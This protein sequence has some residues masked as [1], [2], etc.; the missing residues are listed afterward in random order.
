VSDVLSRLVEQLLVLPVYLAVGLL[1][2]AVCVLPVAIRRQDLDL[3][4]RLAV[5]HL[6]MDTVLAVSVFLLARELP[7]YGVLAGWLPANDGSLGIVPAS[8]LWLV[9]VD[10]IYY[11]M[12]RAQHASALLWAA[13]ELHHSDPAMNVTTAWRRHWPTDTIMEAVLVGQAA[14]L[15]APSS[16]VLM[17]ATIMRSVMVYAIHANT[18]ASLGRYSWAI[19]TPQHHRIHHSIEPQHRDKNFSAAWPVWD[20]LFGTYVAPIPGVYPVTG[21]IDA[22]VPA[23]AWEASVR[24][25]QTWRR[26]FRHRYFAKP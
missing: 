10:L 1:L 4:L 8:V 16:H 20:I 11:W 6:T 19:A 25:L 15:F 23:S 13:H 21:V 24:P 18:T 12:H 17:T 26:V 9:W 2:E 14:Y 3:N 7:G 22:P 5:L